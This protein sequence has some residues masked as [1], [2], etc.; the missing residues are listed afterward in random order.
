MLDL[1][2]HNF[3]GSN[4]PNWVPEPDRR[5]T[6]NI[7]ST[8]LVTLS[9]CVWTA[10][11]LNVPEH[12]EGKVKQL[13]RKAGWTL[14]GLVS[15]EAIAYTA[16]QQYSQAREISQ[17]MNSRNSPP[18]YAGH[19]RRTRD[20]GLWGFV[21]S[22]LTSPESIEDQAVGVPNWT[23][24]HGFL[25]AMGGFAIEINEV[26][27][28]NQQRVKNFLPK[29]A[30]G[31]LRTR[32]TLTPEAL[33]FLK[34]KGLE[35]LIP[36][37]PRESI[38][39]KSKGSTFAKAL[40]CFQTS[41]FCIGCVN[42]FAQ[43]LSISLLELNTL[44]H[45]LCTLFIYAMWWHKPLDVGEPEK[46]S[47]D[48]NLTSGDLMNCSK[49]IAAMCVRSKLDNKLSESTHLYHREGLDAFVFSAE[50]KYLERTAS[51]GC[52]IDKDN[53]ARSEELEAVFGNRF[54]VA[55][56]PLSDI[57]QRFNCL[58][59]PFDVRYEPKL[60]PYLIY[61]LVY[62]PLMQNYA[63][64]KSKLAPPT[65]CLVGIRKSDTLLELVRT[66]SGNATKRIISNEKPSGVWANVLLHDLDSKWR[67]PEGMGKKKIGTV[68]KF[69]S[70]KLPGVPLL[71]HGI[72]KPQPDP[73]QPDPPQANSPRPNPPQVPLVSRPFIDIS[74]SDMGR[75]LLAMAY[76][77]LS[78][79]P[80]DLLV[81][82]ARNLPRFEDYEQY[83][84]LYFGFGLVSL[85]YGALHCLAWN[86][87]FTSTAET[88]LW[89][90]S[91]VAIA[92]SGVFVVALSAWQKYPPF[93]Y[94][95]F[96]M[97][98]VDFMTSLWKKLHMPLSYAKL[99]VL[100]LNHNWLDRVLLWSLA[101]RMQVKYL[102]MYFQSDWPRTWRGTLYLYSTRALRFLHFIII[103]MG[104]PLFN[105][106]A[107]A[108]FAAVIAALFLAVLLRF[109]FDFAT[110]CFIPLYFLARGYL[111]VVAFINL[112]HLSDS[113]YSVP[114]WSK[115]VPHIG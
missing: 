38:D 12:K 103:A 80:P 35:H 57:L 55:S 77:E 2:G 20:R 15:P 75:W 112:A 37:P 19:R 62:P 107:F 90:L 18:V 11:H 102:D 109:V 92:A 42:R 22:L 33:R 31:T 60:K 26:G 3:T 106:L 64:K 78:G 36:V 113:A 54:P 88:I 27:N 101:D 97:D 24:V 71:D 59:N 45:A 13:V 79:V 17:A 40:V 34:G 108:F 105:A 16:Y 25:A 85:I 43:G 95:S 67:E 100:M 14:M 69:L 21:T 70:H 63:L 72:V 4:D 68:P 44:G 49:L 96:I 23:I 82:R 28:A 32:L 47:L 81:D 52:T 46:V 74:Y 93:R 98:V 66:T 87:P 50:Y 61:S 76:E 104:L 56:G 84:S 30:T 58:V 9:L 94:L 91:S 6:F 89:R 48:A 99:K 5:G 1:F 41:W 51:F 65:R 10:I 111:V 115:Y 53:L 73:P 29:K 86:A 83:T 7:L 8:C 110:C 114:S 39:D